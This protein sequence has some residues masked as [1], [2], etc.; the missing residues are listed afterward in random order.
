[1]TVKTLL[2]L[3]VLM[4]LLNLHAGELSLPF[5]FSSNMVLQ[6]DAPVPVWGHAA[7]GVDVTVAFKG[8]SLTAKAD[9][10]GNWIVRLAPMAADKKPADMIVSS[11]EGESRRFVNILIGEVWLASGQSNMWWPLKNADNGAKETA[12]ANWHEIRLLN[13]PQKVTVVPEGSCGWTVCAPETAE[14]FSAVAYFFG[15]NLHREL[16]VPVGLINSSWGATICELW[17]SPESLHERIPGL[18]SKIDDNREDLA[19]FSKKIDAYDSARN[20]LIA[21]E[22]GL[23]AE[24]PEAP[25]DLDDSGWKSLRVPCEWGAAGLGKPDFFTGAMWLRKTV[26]LPESWAGKDLLLNLGEIDEIDQTWFNGSRVGGEGSAKDVVTKYWNQPRRYRVPGKFVKAGK[27]TIAVWVANFVGEGGIIGLNT[28]LLTLALGK[29]VDAPVVIN[30]EWKYKESIYLPPNP[31]VPS[32]FGAL[33]SA[34]IKPLAPFAIR[35]V[36]WYQGESNMFQGDGEVYFQKMAALINCWRQ[37][38]GIGDFPFLIVQ[39]SAF[40]PPDPNPAGGGWANLREAQRKLLEIPNAGLAVTY[41]IGDET[42]IHPG[43][44]QAVGKRLALWALAKTYGK[45]IVFSGP[46]FNDFTVEDGKIRVFFD[47]V[48]NGLA[49]GSNIPDTVLRGFSICGEDG[50][51]L[52]ADAA[53]DGRTVLVSSPKVKKPGGVRYAFSGNPDKANLYNKE[54]LPAAPFHADD[55][56][57][58]QRGASR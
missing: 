8:Q 44:K 4:P 26:E 52:W 58:G 51:W 18:K 27:N 19:D 16:D 39:I 36:I 32:K 47:R 37:T 1:M 50:Q 46:L 10:A 13:A 43:N 3:S 38:W 20:K 28:K 35:G 48:G 34:M 23:K 49:I 17:T 40:G 6:R 56:S 14:K 29:G 7:P 31:G 41:D 30:G 55:K 45:D 54:G 53:I 24:D 15:R 12:A 5:V 21:I 11:S 57:R 22:A 25:P 9:H 42:N 33:Y 2:C